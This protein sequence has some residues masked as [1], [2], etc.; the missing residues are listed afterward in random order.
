MAIPSRQI[1]WSTQSNLLWQISKR[2]ELLIKVMAANNTT[3]TTT[4]STSTSTS[5]S[6]TTTTTT[7]LGP[8]LIQIGTQ[9]W[10]TKNL[11]V[12]T[13]RDGT[14]IPESDWDYYEN[15]PAN[16][17]IFGKLYKGN[18][19]KDPKELAPVGYHIPTDDEWTILTDYLGGLSVAGGKMKS[20]D[21]TWQSPNTGATNESGFTGLA[22]GF[23]QGFNGAFN[24]QSITGYFWSSS[25]LE[26]DSTKL[27]ARY[28]Q[29]GN[30]DAFRFSPSKIN[31][32]SVR[33]IKD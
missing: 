16:G 14:L 30:D 3:T 1:G 31:G 22:A 20:T 27:W 33:L 6:S 26:S 17:E 19:I 4:S 25:E 11:D 32:F 15:N 29:S 18:V 5:T 23:L 8:N 13:Y 21:A 24:N 10:T 2:L 9:I 28:L 7:T 12:A